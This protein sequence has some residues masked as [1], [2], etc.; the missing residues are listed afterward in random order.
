MSKCRLY[1]VAVAVF[2]GSMLSS[3]PVFSSCYWCC[4]DSVEANQ[5][6]AT[7]CRLYDYSW[8]GE[9][10]YYSNTTM[11][12]D[13]VDPSWSIDYEDRSM[14]DCEAQ[15]SSTMQPPGAPFYPRVVDPDVAFPGTS[16]TENNIMRCKFDT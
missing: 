2:A 6:S 8:S 15:C 7:I 3:V 13:A 4:S 9:I 11:I 1:L 16:G 10:H 12:A 5:Q 14:T